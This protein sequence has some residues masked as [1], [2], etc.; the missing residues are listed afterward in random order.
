MW[1]NREISP[2]IKKNTDLIQV[3]RGPRQCGKTS[4][5]LNL[6]SSF[7]EISLDDPSMRELAQNDPELF[8][9]QFEK[10]RI[11]ID[12]VQYAPALFPSLKRRADL[13]KETTLLTKQ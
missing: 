12:E 4:L 1:I 3:L 9:S 8:L 10:D 5:L 13:Y 7:E 6:D 2:F 11:F